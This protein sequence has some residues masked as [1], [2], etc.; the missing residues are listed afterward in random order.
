MPR[1]KPLSIYCTGIS[2]AKTRERASPVPFS[3]WNVV[4]LEGQ[5]D[6]DRSGDHFLLKKPPDKN[7]SRFMDPGMRGRMRG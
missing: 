6:Q 3:L 7:S 5:V 1:V 2:Q 4:S